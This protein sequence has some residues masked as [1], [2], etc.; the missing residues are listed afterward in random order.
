MLVSDQPYQPLSSSRRLVSKGLKKRSDPK[1][2]FIASGRLS[3]PTESK[4]KKECQATH[5]MDAQKQQ[6]L[7]EAAQQFADALAQ[8]YRAVSE[9][10]GYDAGA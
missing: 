8:S 1:Y 4:L 7:N 2:V 9:L 10:G 6:R 5:M 3:R